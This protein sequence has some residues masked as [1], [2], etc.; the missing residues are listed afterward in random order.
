MICTKSIYTKPY[1]LN[2]KKITKMNLRLNINTT[3]SKDE[4]S[5]IKTLVL[6]KTGLEWIM[7][8]EHSLCSSIPFLCYEDSQFFINELKNKEKIR[9]FSC[10]EINAKRYKRLLEKYGFYCEVI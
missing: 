6:S 10:D 4:N 8:P 2:N 9:L 3:I 5:S 7:Y 1:I